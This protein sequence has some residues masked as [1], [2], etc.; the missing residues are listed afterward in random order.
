MIC[1]RVCLLSKCFSL[2]FSCKMPSCFKSVAAMAILDFDRKEA[3]KIHCKKKGLS[4]KKM[5]NL[6]KLKRFEKQT[7]MRHGVWKSRL[8]SVN[9]S[10]DPTPA[11]KK[12]YLSQSRVYKAGRFSVTETVK[13]NV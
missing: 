7:A 5:W 1:F 9:F 6:E 10:D 2:P 13:M 8:S 4:F 12:A 11:P 3:L